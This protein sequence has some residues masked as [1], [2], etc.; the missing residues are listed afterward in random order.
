MLVEKRRR[1]KEINPSEEIGKR[2]RK[3][4]QAKGLT[5]L[6]VAKAFGTTAQ[7]ISQF[8]KEGIKYYDDIQRMSEILGCDL[9]S[10]ENDK[11]GML[12]EIGKEILYSLIES[13]EPFSSNEISGY[14]DAVFL[15]DNRSL[16]GFNG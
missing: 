1:M 6:D 12:G 7:H 11:E 10:N 4:R 14:K 8:E 13:N 3:F 9:T 2:L 5:Q 16:Y 15:L